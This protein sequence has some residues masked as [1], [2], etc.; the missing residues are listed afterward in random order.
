MAEP[1]LSSSNDDR[2][3]ADSPSS[4]EPARTLLRFRDEPIAGEVD[5]TPEIPI[6]EPQLP[7]PKGARPA[8]DSLV[9]LDQRKELLNAT[10]QQKIGQGYQI[11]SQTDTTAVLVTKG[12]RRWF[13]VFGS[14]AET[15]QGTSIDEHGRTKTRRL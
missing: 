9:T 1:N 4:R 15:R 11:E 10:L 5:R 2:P 12:R 8:P 13:G 14:A 7:S 3:V 6:T